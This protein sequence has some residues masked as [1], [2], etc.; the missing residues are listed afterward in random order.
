MKQFFTT[1]AA[2]VIGLTAFAQTQSA[3]VTDSIKMD[4]GRINDVY[5]HSTNGQ[6]KKESNKNW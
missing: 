3:Y 6:V 1:L 4:A 2:T 5:Y